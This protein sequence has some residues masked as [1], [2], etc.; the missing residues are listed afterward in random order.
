MVSQEKEHMIHELVDASE[1]FFQER[2][3]LARCLGVESGFERSMGK[4]EN[5]PAL[6]SIRKRG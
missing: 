6:A 4:S 1:C 2:L 3:T 5:Q